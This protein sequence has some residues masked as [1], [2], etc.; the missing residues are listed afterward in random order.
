[1][2]WNRLPKT[3]SEPI[4]GARTCIRPPWMVEVQVLQEQKTCLAGDGLRQAISVHVS[5]Y[6][7]GSSGNIAAFC[8]VRQPGY[9]TGTLAI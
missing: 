1:M 6:L 9:F 8:V 2:N 7:W 5:P 4:R 3:R